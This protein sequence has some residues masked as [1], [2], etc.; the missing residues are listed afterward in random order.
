MKSKDLSGLTSGIALDLFEDCEF[1]DAGAIPNEWAVVSIPMI[2]TTITGTGHANGLAGFSVYP[3]PVGENSV[4]SFS[5]EQAGK[6]KLTL[7]D[8]LG[9]TVLNIESGDF[10][11]GNHKVALKASG[12]KPGIYL[13]K[14]EKMSNGEP[15]SDMIK[16]VVSY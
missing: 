3:N 13:L 14:S 9:N 1:A 12:I 2:N 4:I 8:I 15:I 10:S 5:L 6:V 16:L 11:A 7:T